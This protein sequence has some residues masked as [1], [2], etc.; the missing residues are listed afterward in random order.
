MQQHILRIIRINLGQT[1]KTA[2]YPGLKRVFYSLNSTI[3]FTWKQFLLQ[4]KK[5]E[6]WFLL[7][8]QYF[9]SSSLKSIEQ[10]FRYFLFF[11]NNK[12]YH[13]RKSFRKFPTIYCPRNFS[14]LARA[15]KQ[16]KKRKRNRKENSPLI[17][18]LRSR[19]RRSSFK[20]THPE[21]AIFLARGE[22]KGVRRGW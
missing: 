10:I 21:S 1:L 15:L 6:S 22:T 18:E 2:L 9:H 17:P 4:K 12:M 14:Q 16:K 5:K 7:P 3:Q 13:R 19:E 8:L 11:F 20:R